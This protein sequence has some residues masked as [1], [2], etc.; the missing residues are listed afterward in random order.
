VEKVC[1][2]CREPFYG[3]LTFFNL[4]KLK[5]CQL[6]KSVLQATMSRP[7]RL[8]TLIRNSITSSIETLTVTFPTLDDEVFDAIMEESEA[9]EAKRDG[10]FLLGLA[11]LNSAL[12]NSVIRGPFDLPAGCFEVSLAFSAPAF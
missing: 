11:F 8:D 10:N 6:F 7:P 9:G 3:H 4:F 1:G 2:K 5:D 12:A